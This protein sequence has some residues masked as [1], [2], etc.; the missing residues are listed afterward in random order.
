M[1]TQLFKGNFAGA[2]GATGLDDVKFFMEPLFECE[3][4]DNQWIFINGPHK[5]GIE[6]VEKALYEK[7][8]VKSE[9][10]SSS[11]RL[12][13][14][15]DKSPIPQII[16]C[17]LHGVKKPDS[18]LFEQLKPVLN[19][20]NLVVVSSAKMYGDSKFW[21]KFFSETEHPKTILGIWVKHRKTKFDGQ[22]IDLSSS[23]IKLATEN[24]E[25]ALIDWDQVD[26][27][28]QFLGR[29]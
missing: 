12:L 5:N 29:K 13:S 11:V 14:C 22:L 15:Q 24:M 21:Q 18:V 7:F 19:K 4:S 23:R 27:G 20:N 25:S 16:F 10:S 6:H 26:S 3:I 2:S 9:G 1:S 8:K 28:E 17:N